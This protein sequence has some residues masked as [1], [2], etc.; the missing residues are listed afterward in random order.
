MTLLEIL[1][2]I[3][4]VSILAGLGFP[5]VQRIREA[6]RRG[7]CENQLRQIAL[8]IQLYHSAHRRLPAHGGGTAEQNGMRMQPVWQSNHHRLAYTVATLP[9][10]EQ[11]NLWQQIA[12]PIKMAPA[13]TY[14]SMGPV[15]WYNELGENAGGPPNSETRYMPWSTEIAI[16]RCPSDPAR[17]AISGAVNYAACLGDG[18]KEVGCAF[19]RPQ[20]RFQGDDSPVR[21]DD[22]TKRGMFANW[23]AFHWRD[24]ADGLTQTLLLGEIIVS[25]GSREFRGSVARKV[26]DIIDHTSFCR[27][28][29]ADGK[30]LHW[31]DAA[32]RGTRWADAGVTFTGFGTI[33]SP[34]S[35]SCTQQ[36]YSRVYDNWFG[37]VMSSTSW[38]SGGVNVAFCDGS[39]RFVS[40]SVDA[41]CRDAD[42]SSVY[43]SNPRHGP[44]S[45]SPFGVWGAMGTRAASD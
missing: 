31:F 17:A 2:V 38:H 13:I 3:G 23:H 41:S 37:G 35:P 14:P 34:N 21:Y 39:I 36:T 12:S 7:Q 15:P 11:Q 28:V 19:Q 40:D 16:Y 29:V 9:F 42:D 5:A 27:D 20:H 33:L 1:V 6:A 45:A 18:V 22:A 10:I 44:G 30:I 4:V 26:P 8:G 25:D 43:T 24:C 32:P